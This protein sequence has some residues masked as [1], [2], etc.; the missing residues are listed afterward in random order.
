MQYI[1]EVEKFSGF[2]HFFGVYLREK[3]TFN[4]LLN[5]L[6][7]LPDKETDASWDEREVQAS[8]RLLK[9]ISDILNMENSQEFR[10]HALKHDFLI[11]ILGRLKILTG[12][13][14][15]HYE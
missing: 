7:G 6:S 4:L 14:T 12:T 8:Q 2:P 5:I 15:R 1:N 11:I 13:H 10:A 3:E 9:I